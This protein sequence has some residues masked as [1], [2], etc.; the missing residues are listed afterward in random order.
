MPGS[1]ALALLYPDALAL[2]CAVWA[3]VLVANPRAGPAGA[4]RR[5]RAWRPPRR[6][7]VRTGCW[8]RSRWPGSPTATVAASARWLAAAAPLGAAAA[9]HGFL[10]SR[11]GDPLTFTHAQARWRRGEPWDLVWGV[12]G[13]LASGH[14]QTV[15]EVLLG[16]R[17]DRPLRAP[18]APR[19]GPAHLGGLRHRGAGRCRSAPAAG[20][21]SPARP[22]SPSR[23]C[24]PRQAS[25]V[26][27]AAGW[28]RRASR[29]T[30][31]CSSRSPG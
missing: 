10:W 23:W 16:P 11:T 14:Y 3:C 28:R 30:S 4:G 15:A 9:V 12:P 22:C 31:H 17:R 7:R 24:G 5:G 2:A 29:S 27:A 26:C 21:R 1:F 13:N 25:P 19:P 6:P 20:S 18:L 8:W